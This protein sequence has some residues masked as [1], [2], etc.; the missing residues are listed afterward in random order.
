M[1]SPWSFLGPSL[2]RSLAG[3]LGRGPGSRRRGPE[4]ARRGPGCATW[5]KLCL[6]HGHAPWTLH[7][8]TDGSTAGNRFLIV[9]LPE[10]CPHTVGPPGLDRS[11]LRFQKMSMQGTQRQENHEEA[12]SLIQ[13]SWLRLGGRN[14]D[15]R[16]YS[17]SG[18][19]LFQL[20]F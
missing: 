18:Y 15:D 9:P 1:G 3:S 20:L 14:K 19:I 11:D 8:H 17:D 16:E 12:I 2:A 13:E 10:D 7:T 4:A 6:L 5:A